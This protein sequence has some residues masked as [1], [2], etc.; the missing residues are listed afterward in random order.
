MPK[1]DIG[2]GEVFGRLI[3]LHELETRRRKGGGTERWFR[4]RCECGKEGDF[5]LGRLRSGKTKSCGCLV[6][7]PDPSVKKPKSAKKA[8]KMS[9]EYSV[10]KGI[11][12]RCYRTRSKAYARYGGRGIAMCSGWRSSFQLFLKDMGPRPSLSHSIDRIENSGNY[13]C[14]HCE[15]CVEKSWPMNC[16]W[17]DKS[18]QRRNQG[19]VV[20]LTFAGETLCMSDMAKR[21]GMTKGTLRDRILRGMS[22]KD[23]LTTPVRRIRRDTQ[24]MQVPESERNSEWRRDK[25]RRENRKDS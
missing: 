1:L 7:L 23:A 25:E 15:E 3:V 11:K 18:T 9:P 19:D 20:M 16:R 17:A 12:Q 14:G 5:L 2:V 8:V 6:V 4:C 10:Y 13:S 24:F 22:L 21:Y